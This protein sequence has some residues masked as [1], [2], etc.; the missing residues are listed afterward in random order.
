MN[1]QQ[2]KPISLSYQDA[3]AFLYKAIDYEKL[4][5]FQYNAST[6]SLDRMKKLL[7][8]IGNPHK[9]L[10]CIHITGTKGKGSTAIMTATVMECAGHSGQP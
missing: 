5:S 8:Y 3:L 9:G 1:N 7:A 4:I 10:P 6:F 2:D